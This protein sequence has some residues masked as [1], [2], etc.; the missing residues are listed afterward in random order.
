MLQMAFLKGILATNSAPLVS[1]DFNHNSHSSIFDLTQTQV[2]KGKASVECFLGTIMS[3][4]FQIEC[5]I[6]L[7]RLLEINLI[8]NYFQPLL[9]I[10]KYSLELRKNLF[11]QGMLLIASIFFLF[12]LVLNFINRR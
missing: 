1:K 8:L 6:Q 4:V 9:S 2:I 5:A 3:G 10:L 7:F 12:L 11:G